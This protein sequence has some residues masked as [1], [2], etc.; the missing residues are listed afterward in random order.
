MVGHN[1]IFEDY[2][3]LAVRAVINPE[4]RCYLEKMEDIG[5]DLSDAEELR[6]ALSN[7]SI[8]GLGD[9]EE[10]DK[11]VES[12]EEEDDDGTDATTLEVEEAIYLTFILQDLS[13]KMMMAKRLRVV[14]KMEMVVSPPPTE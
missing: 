9:K 6:D 1:G 13:T 12:S 2:M 11:G 3:D 14:R 7:L 8:I 4:I 5:T 10:D